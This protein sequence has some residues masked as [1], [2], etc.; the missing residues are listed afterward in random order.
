MAATERVV[1]LM[2][3]QEKA[4]LEQKAARA[5]GVSTAELV[6]RAVDAYDETGDGEAEMLKAL[7]E[8]FRTTHAETLA[9]LDRTDRK[10]D[11]TLAAVAK[12]RRPA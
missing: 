10:L 9:Q 5:G 6:R 4:A 1:V 2:S 7:I 12:L 8:A 11:E 3:P